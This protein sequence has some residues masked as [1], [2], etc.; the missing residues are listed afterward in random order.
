MENVNT[1]RMDKRA[2]AK[3]KHNTPYSSKHVRKT[4]AMLQQQAAANKKTTK[5]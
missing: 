2:S 1:S 4:E 3:N 5:K